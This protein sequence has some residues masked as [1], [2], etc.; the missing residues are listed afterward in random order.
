MTRLLLSLLVSIT[1]VAADI[2]LNSEFGKRI[3]ANAEGRQ[4]EENNA[5]FLADYSIKFQ[6]CHHVQQWNDEADEENDVRIMTKRL[7]RFRLCPADSCTNQNGSGCNSKYGDYVVDMDTF[8]EAYVEAMQQDDGSFCADVASD[9]T[10]YCANSDENDCMY[11]CYMLTAAWCYQ[12]NDDDQDGEEDFNALQYAECQRVDFPNNNQNNN[13]GERQLEDQ[14]QEYYMGTYC[15]NQGG[16]V[17]IGVFT[18]DT[19]TTFASSGESMFENAYGFEIPYSRGSLISN[20]CYGCVDGGD[21]DGDDNN[22]GDNN[23]NQQ[24]KEMCSNV[25][26]VSGK[27]ET[28]MNIDYPNESSCN[29]IEGVKII[30][31]DGV[32]RTTN[33]K[34]SKAA[35]IGIGLFTTLSVLLVGY[36]FYLRTKL[37]RA[38][39]NLAA[40]SQTKL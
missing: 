3:L 15:A 6:G 10:D 22:N 13:G 18:D 32:I 1:S 7:A 26:Q 37:A 33:T 21:G 12:A 5:A 2:P 27:C 24:A 23:G 11:E 35:A 4:L 34:K 25:Y 17:R 36:V 16:Q 38:Q 9:C 31:N 19:C 8:V 20:R 30:Q 40:A 14:Q 28:R 29:Y 39:V